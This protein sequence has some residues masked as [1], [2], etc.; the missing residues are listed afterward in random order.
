MN[1]RQV[2]LFLAE[3]TDETFRELRRYKSGSSASACP[4]SMSYHNASVPYDRVPVVFADPDRK[5]I[6]GDV[7][8]SEKPSQDDPRWPTKCEGCD[9]IFQPEDPWQVF[10][11]AI[12][13]RPDTGEEFTLRKAPVGAVWDCPWY[14]SKGPDGKCICIMTPG[15][16]WMP[17]LPSSSGTPWHRTGTL[18]KITCTPS[19]LIPHSQYHAWLRDGVLVDC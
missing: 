6:R 5:T 16:E 3:P 9:Y 19:I 11:E 1:G 10:V 12:Y 17:D 2:T 4:G 18:P 7:P 13:R 8:E 14:I 15:G